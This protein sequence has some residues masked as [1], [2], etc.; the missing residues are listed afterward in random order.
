[1]KKII[2]IIS[3]IVILFIAVTAIMTMTYK[4]TNDYTS[5][6]LPKNTHVNGVDC[7]G[8]TYG[9]AV[10]KL[11][12][13]WN[14]HYII[15]N[16]SLKEKLAEYTDFNC[17]YAINDSIKEL[18]KHY[19]IPAALN[20]Y[21]HIPLRASIPM[22]ISEYDASLKERIT[23]SDFLHNPNATESSDA[24]V[25]VTDPEFPIIPEKLGTKVDSEK[26]FR[27]ILY[28]IETGDFNFI[29][30]EKAYRIAPKV[31][32]DDPQL[33]EYQNFCKKYLAQKITYEMGDSTHTISPEILSTLFKDDM[34][35][36]A[37]EK[38]VQDYINEMANKYD[39]VGA[40]RSF[41]TLAGKDIK[42]KGGTYGWTIDQKKESAQLAA[43]INSHSDISRKP[44]YS[45]ESYGEYTT[46]MGNTYVDIDLTKQQVKFFRDGEEK[47]SCYVVTGSKIRGDSTPE[48][49]YYVL[50]RL[51]NVTMRGD[52]DDGTR[53]EEPASYWMGVTWNGIGM[54]DSS[55]RTKFGGDI[56]KTNGS[57][58]CINMPKKEIPKLFKLVE[59][60]MPVVMHY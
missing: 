58:G 27:D 36:K 53:Y 6:R 20:H 54:H 31:T 46:T 1:M 5:D 52:N 21:L 13:R 39:N 41:K 10:Q 37:D 2:L 26:F 9:D 42:I 22:L 18:K 12:S 38:A 11:T 44:I 60:D 47:F 16:G 25:D 55:W 30:D 19:L 45:F 32:S 17:S 48:G 8:L 24:Y 35:G 51:R 14:E 4:N 29:Y 57:H 7:S 43:D 28:H 3:A 23:S 56:W 49:T 34:S 15:V 40:E 50:N 59:E 33:K